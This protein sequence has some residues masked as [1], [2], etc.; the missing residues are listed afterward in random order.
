MFIQT[1]IWFW[2]CDSMYGMQWN[3]F[4]PIVGILKLIFNLHTWGKIKVGTVTKRNES[5]D[6]TTFLNVDCNVLWFKN[7][8]RNI[9]KFTL[10][11]KWDNFKTKFL[12]KSKRDC[13]LVSLLIANFSFSSNRW[14]SL[15][16]P[17]NV[18]VFLS[19]L[20]HGRIADCVF[21]FLL[22]FHVFWKIQTFCY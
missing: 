16:L 10:I 21:Y 5:R 4:G 2:K 3:C 7:S 15:Q 11:Q 14:A 20:S 9:S 19:L 22:Y 8:A 17:S 1:S 12:R 18:H 13:S 6:N